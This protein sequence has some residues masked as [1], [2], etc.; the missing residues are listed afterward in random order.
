MAELP[1]SGRTALVTGGAVRLGRAIALGLAAQGA[2]IVLHYLS[3]EAEAERT[4][5]EIRALGR[6]CLIV[7]TDLQS[8]DAPQTLFD[9]AQ[10]IGGAN[11]LVSSAAVFEKAPFSGTTLDLWDRTFAINLRAPFFLAQTF[12]ARCQKGDILFLADANAQRAGREYLAYSLTKTAIA[13]L[14]RTL[15]KTLAPGIRVNAV[16]PGAILPP[17][18]EGPEYLERLA[19]RIPLQRIGSPED[20]V[21]AVLYLLQS[22][23]VTGEVLAVSGGSEL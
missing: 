14:T 8:P 7:R 12:A 18:G 16:A 15:A 4:A 20:I 11:I 23:Y 1:L 5:E 9:A 21:G 22:P 3:S 17:P 2:D 10:P 19:K 6:R 13:A